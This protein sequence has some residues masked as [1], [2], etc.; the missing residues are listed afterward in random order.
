MKKINIDIQKK[1][2]TLAFTADYAKDLTGNIE[3]VQ[4]ETTGDRWLELK[5]EQ[6]HFLYCKSIGI[7]ANEGKLVKVNIGMQLL[8]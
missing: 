1:V 2:G 4:D 3:M 5:T 6:G 8:S 7:M